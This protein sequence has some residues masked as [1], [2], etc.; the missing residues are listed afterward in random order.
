MTEE[1]FIVHI[2]DCDMTVG[3]A[4]KILNRIEYDDVPFDPICAWKFNNDR[5]YVVADARKNSKSVRFD[6]YKEVE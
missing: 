4:I 3:E 5:H 2:H 1:K 6:I